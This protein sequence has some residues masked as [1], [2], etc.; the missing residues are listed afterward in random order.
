MKMEK[1]V[2]PE[3]SAHEIQTPGNHT[4]KKERIRYLEHDEKFE[5]KYRSLICDKSVT[6]P[7]L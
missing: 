2:Y 3:K 1:T 6:T 7:N 5:I 4:Q